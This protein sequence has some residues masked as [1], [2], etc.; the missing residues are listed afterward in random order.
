MPKNGN[1]NEVRDALLEAVELSL[2]AQ[3]RAVRRL[4][5]GGKAVEPGRR[6]A[7]MSQVDL[8]YDILL[9]AGVPL[10]VTELLR[11]V[12]ADHGVRLDR[13]SVV[14]ALS[15]KVARGVRFVRTD[16]NTFAVRKE[17]GR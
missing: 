2:D 1:Q 3:L 6:R 11:R 9:R 7:G 16:R 10:H 15:K 5:K 12:A 13:E 14:S 8:V 17:A 4:R